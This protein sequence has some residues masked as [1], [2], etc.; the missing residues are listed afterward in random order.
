MSV[1]L[2]PVALKYNRILKLNNLSYRRR[3]TRCFKSP[4]ILLTAPQLY[5]QEGQHELT[6]Q[7]AAN[8]RQDLGAT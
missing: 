5:E 7:R 6:G 3:T 4:K 1:H 8:F 2:C